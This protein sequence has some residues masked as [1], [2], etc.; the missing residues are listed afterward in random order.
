M[1]AYGAKLGLLESALV[2]KVQPNEEK[3]AFKLNP[4]FVSEPAPLHRGQ[5]KN[6]GYLQDVDRYAK[7]MCDDTLVEQFAALPQ[8][9]K[10]KYGYEW[11]LYNLLE[12]LVKKCDTRIRKAQEKLGRA[13]R[14]ASST[15]A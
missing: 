9:E 8:E 12:D 14:C 13:V 3:L 4:S 6:E 1:G 15:P 11:D 2:S 7:M 5:P 10:D